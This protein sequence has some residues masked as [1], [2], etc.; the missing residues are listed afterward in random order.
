MSSKRRCSTRASREGQALFP[1]FD[2]DGWLTQLATAIALARLKVEA[3][4]ALPGVDAADKYNN[5]AYVL[6]AGAG[7]LARKQALA[8]EKLGEATKFWEAQ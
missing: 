3:G 5:L 6:P 1:L 7:Y 8:A 2:V 4:L